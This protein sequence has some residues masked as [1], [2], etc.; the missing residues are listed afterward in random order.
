MKTLLTLIVLLTLHGV[1]FAQFTGVLVLKRHYK[2]I[3]RYYPGTTITFINQDN[4][5]VSGI[6]TGGAKDTVY[7]RF[8]DVRQGL[9]QWE[10][11]GLDTLRDFPMAYDISAIKSIIRT[12][13]HLNYAADGAVLIGAAVGLVVLEVVNGA[14]LHQSS[15][16][17]LSAGSLITAAGLAGLGTW[18]ITLQNKH[19]RLG[20]KYHLEYYGFTPGPTPKG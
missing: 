9:N 15:R 5:Q 17:W 20:K 1:P 19:Y 7:L 2:T 4:Q 14:Y 3:E 10:L 8:L 13:N 6:V 12:R 18:L 16:E 11:P